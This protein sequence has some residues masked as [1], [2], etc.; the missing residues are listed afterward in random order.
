MFK[1]SRLSLPAWKGNRKPL[2]F[3][4]MPGKVVARTFFQGMR[5]DQ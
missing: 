4:S 3:I 1:A 2:L 5:T